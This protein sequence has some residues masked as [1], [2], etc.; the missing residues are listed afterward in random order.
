LGPQTVCVK[1]ATTTQR[2]L[3]DFIQQAHRQ[4]TVRLFKTFD[5]ALQA[6]LATECTMLTTDSSMLAMS[7][8]NY[9]ETDS[10]IYLFPDIISREPL[11]PYVPGGDGH[12]LEIARAVIQTT[13]LAEELGVTSANIDRLRAARDIRYQQMV[14][15]VPAGLAPDWSYQVIRQVGNYGEIFERE[16]G[17][18]SAYRMARGLNRLWSDGGLLYSPR[19]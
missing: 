2:N 6:F 9:R 11:T 19:P 3:E 18:R 15:D 12:W 16:L 13:V 5:E 17:G 10:S 4:W 1:T 8:A 7:L 14:G